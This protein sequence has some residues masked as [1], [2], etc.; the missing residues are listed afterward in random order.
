M[1]HD[2][3]FFASASNDGTV[4][5][6]ESE[7]LEGNSVANRSKQTLKNTS[8]PGKILQKL[9]LLFLYLPEI[10]NICTQTSSESHSLTRIC[11]SIRRLAMGFWRC[12]TDFILFYLYHK[13]ISKY[14]IWQI[15]T[16]VLFGLYRREGEGAGFLWSFGS[17]PITSDIHRPGRHKHL[18]VSLSIL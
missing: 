18:Q 10:T 7:K 11:S 9:C 12:Y 2:H 17:F 14:D 3:A 4:K 1:S 8:L 6:W 15:F 13:Y 5:L 16:T